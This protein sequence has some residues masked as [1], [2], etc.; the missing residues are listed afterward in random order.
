MTRGGVHRHPC[1]V[2][3]RSVAWELANCWDCNAALCA[4]G[5]IPEVDD[6]FQFRAAEKR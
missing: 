4:A 6:E 3:R 5:H 2:C 1:R